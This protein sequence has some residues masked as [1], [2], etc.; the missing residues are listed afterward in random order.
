MGLRIGHDD[1]AFAITRGPGLPRSHTRPHCRQRHDQP[2][3]DDPPSHDC[4]P[5]WFTSC[6]TGLARNSRSRHF[7]VFHSFQFESGGEDAEKFL[8]ES[9]PRMI[10][11][12]MDQAVTERNRTRTPPEP[13]GMT[14]FFIR[15]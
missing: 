6:Y 9:A 12:A 14:H 11:E 8:R 4:L 15:A 7:M 13:R 1:G 10:V 2:S 5:K 3:C